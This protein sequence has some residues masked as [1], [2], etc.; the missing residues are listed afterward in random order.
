MTAQVIPLKEPPPTANRDALLAAVTDLHALVT[1]DP[2]LGASPVRIY[3]VFNPEA[4]R[5]IA[6]SLDR[7][8]RRPAVAYGLIAYDFPFALQLLQ[9]T[10]TRLARE[11]AIEIASSSAGLQADCLRAAAAALGI[12][13]SP[14]QA[15]DDA[16]LKSIFFPN[17]QETVIQ[18]FQLD[19]AA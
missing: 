6:A 2:V 7:A 12:E 11:R 13:V 10:A 17:T 4:Q 19:L 8:P 9:S 16:A 5:R 15:F 18:L 14:I 1:L 3:F